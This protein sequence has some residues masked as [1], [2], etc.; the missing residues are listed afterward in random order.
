MLRLRAIPSVCHPFTQVQPFAEQGSPIAGLIPQRVATS[1]RYAIIL[2]LLR[3]TTEELAADGLIA[4]KSRS[5][6]GP[7]HVRRS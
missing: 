2:R 5:G 6:T 4:H 3:E 7:R 1:G